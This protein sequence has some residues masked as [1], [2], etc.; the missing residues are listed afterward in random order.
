MKKLSLCFIMLT[1]FV[2]LFAEIVI[3]RGYLKLEGPE[4]WNDSYVIFT[5]TTDNSK[6]GASNTVF[7]KG[8]YDRILSK[9]EYDSK[10]WFKLRK[11]RSGIRSKVGHISYGS[12]DDTFSILYD[13]DDF[14]YY[15]D[16]SLINK[17]AINVI[18]S[19]TS[20]MEKNLLESYNNIINNYNK[21]SSKEKNTLQ[22]DWSSSGVEVGWTR[23]VDDRNGYF[24]FKIYVKELD[25]VFYFEVND[26]T[27]VY[28]NEVKDSNAK[29]YNNLDSKVLAICSEMAVNKTIVFA[30]QKSN[31]LQPRKY[32]GFVL[33]K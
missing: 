33:I 8:S 31:V 10:D 20:V 23:Y 29:S 25:E 1:L 11:N 28:F 17:D 30:V 16:E 7:E 19:I 5:L 21:L 32:C 18:K 14:A 13:L 27:T 2:S 9:F 3:D 24:T 26:N 22:A 15:A 12:W 6:G 4:K